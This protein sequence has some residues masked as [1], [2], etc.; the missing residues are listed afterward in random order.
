MGIFEHFFDSDYLQRSDI[1]RLKS[2]RKLSDRHRRRRQKETESRLESL[3]DE[4]EE[5][6]LITSAL[7]QILM[8]KNG[9]T[10]DELSLA[11]G[12]VRQQQAEAARR[13]QKSGRAREEAEE[14]DR[15][16]APIPTKRRRS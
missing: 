12:K 7:M 6:D 8:E 16:Q 9:V 3:E 4:V 5:L 13:Q 15:P 1:E 10:P 14:G 11:I 2:Q